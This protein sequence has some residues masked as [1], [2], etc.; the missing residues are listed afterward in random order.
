M[1]YLLF[2]CLFWFS[3]NLLAVENMELVITNDNNR[4]AVYL[5]NSSSE[6]MLIN[7]RFALGPSSGPNEI[8]LSIKDRNGK[9]Y[10]FSSKVRLSPAVESDFMMLEVFKLVGRSFDL[11]SLEAYYGLTPG[12]Y[13][14]KAVYHNGRESANGGFVGTLES[15]AVI[16]EIQ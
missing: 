9:D 15:K 12:S 5:L 1:K 11:D 14:V 16:V 7:K 10:P 8:A 3:T 6:E 13:T 2:T 4:L